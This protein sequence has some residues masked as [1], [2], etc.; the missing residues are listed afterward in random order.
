MYTRNYAFNEVIRACIY[1]IKV[2]PITGYYAS[3]HI[4]TLDRTHTHTHTQ[5]TVLQTT[6]TTGNPSSKLSHI[7]VSTSIVFMHHT[8]CIIHYVTYIMHHTLC[9]IHYA[10]YIMHHTL[11]IIHY[12]SYIMHHTLCII[13]YASLTLILQCGN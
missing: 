3:R 13:H 6:V 7:L 8:L 2:C 9:I 4:V 12:A 5:L 11:Y 1:L 10:S